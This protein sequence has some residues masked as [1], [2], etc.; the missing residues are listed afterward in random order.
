M[1]M[2]LSMFAS[3][4]LSA[5]STQNN[6][7]LFTSCIVF[8]GVSRPNILLERSRSS[9]KRYDCEPRLLDNALSIPQRSS[10]GSMIVNARRCVAARRN[11]QATSAMEV[12]R[13][14][15]FCSCVFQW[16]GLVRV[17]FWREGG[18]ERKGGAGILPSLFHAHRARLAILNLS[19][20]S[21]LFLPKWEDGKEE[22]ALL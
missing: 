12:P 17:W 9:G 5:W 1:S 4:P 21:R 14:K 6:R 3:V 15:S 19:R 10:R 2:L 16:R 7:S 20:P 18:K 8:L 13:S 22:P 11:E